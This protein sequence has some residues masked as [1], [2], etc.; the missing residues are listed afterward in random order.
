[1]RS[2]N[3]FVV[4][5]SWGPGRRLTTKKQKGCFQGDGDVRDVDG[6]DSK[7]MLQSCV[8]LLNCLPLPTKKKQILLSTDQTSTH[9]AILGRFRIFSRV[10][11][12]M[13]F[14][15]ENYLFISFT[16]FAMRLF[17]LLLTLGNS[18]LLLKLF[19]F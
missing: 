16:H 19:L 4:V 1:M 9:A 5:R 6:D 18:S 13:L 8:H 2:G 7:T 17:S 11:S 15:F 12:I 3:K 10:L 14:S